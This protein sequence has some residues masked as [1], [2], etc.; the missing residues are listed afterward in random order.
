M[1]AKHAEALEDRLVQDVADYRRALIEQQPKLPRPELERKVGAYA[2][3]RKAALGLFI[4]A[5]S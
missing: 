5:E 1:D 3:S 4:R 2:A